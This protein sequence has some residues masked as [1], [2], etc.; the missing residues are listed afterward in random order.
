MEV[1]LYDRFDAYD[2][3]IHWPSRLRSEAPFFRQFF[4]RYRVQSVLDMACGTGRHALL[5]ARWGLRV[6]GTDLSAKM[7]QRARQNAAADL[8]IQFLVAGFG[9]LREKAPGPYDA[10]TCLGNS[11]PHLLSEAELD[12]ALADFHA[13]MNAGGLLIVQNN[14]YDAILK[15]PRRFMPLAS[16]R[17]A[18]REYLFFR[19][20]D[21][22][23]ERVTFNMVTFVKEGKAW[24]Y[25]ADATLQRPL[26]QAD[27]EAGLR[28]AGFSP[29]ACYGDCQGNPFD[30]QGSPNLVVVGTREF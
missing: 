8:P 26:L 27:L 29:L 30:P 4:R 23:G 1:P 14:N 7:I 5:F 22:E 25:Q 28:K 20:F 9:E 19:F 13:V 11:L 21:F 16:A 6:T 2:L 12:E 17:Q 10:V 3:L 24:S 15:G 18:G